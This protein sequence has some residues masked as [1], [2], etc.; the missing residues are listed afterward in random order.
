MKFKTINEIKAALA[1]SKSAVQ[2]S[3]A[4]KKDDSTYKTLLTVPYSTPSDDI[5]LK[6]MTPPEKK[7]DAKWLAM[8][9]EQRKNKLLQTGRLMGRGDPIGIVKIATRKDAIAAWI[10]PNDFTYDSGT[11]Y[12]AWTYTW[13]YLAATILA[14][15]MIHPL[16]AVPFAWKVGHNWGQYIGGLFFGKD[17]MSNK[18]MYH[19]V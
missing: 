9:V 16:V 11:C 7:N 6:T 8:S 14:Y 17:D 5:D 10:E 19:T 15:I 18:T 13:V 2:V 12:K 1:K 3:G 4:S